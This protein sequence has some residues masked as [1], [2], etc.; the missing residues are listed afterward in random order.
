MFSIFQILVLAIPVLV[1]VE[2]DNNAFYFVRAAVLFLMSST[3]TMLIFFPKMYR[4]HFKKGGDGRAPRF[5]AITR[6]SV[7]RLGI[8]TGKLDSAG[9]HESERNL[10]S[11]R[12]LSSDVSLSK[13]SSSKMTALPR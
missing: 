10:D 4:L 5:Q 9:K 2:N 7:S 12:N 11:D 8:Y 1:I 13:H 6:A 3:V